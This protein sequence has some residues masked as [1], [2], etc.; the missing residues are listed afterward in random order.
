M[1]SLIRQFPNPPERMAVQYP[2]I[3]RDVGKQGAIALLLASHQPM[4]SL[5]VFRGMTRYVREGIIGTPAWHSKTVRKCRGDQRDLTAD[6]VQRVS[7]AWVP[8]WI[9]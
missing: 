6:T 2:L 7:L 8:F 9:C 5:P 3:D 1:K 4:G